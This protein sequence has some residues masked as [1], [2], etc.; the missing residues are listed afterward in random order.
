MVSEYLGHVSSETI[1]GKKFLCAILK[2][3]KVGDRIELKLVAKVKTITDTDGED[4]K[5][6]FEYEISDFEVYSTGEFDDLLE[7]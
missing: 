4:R 2:K 7:D 6:T 1:E 5:P 3:L